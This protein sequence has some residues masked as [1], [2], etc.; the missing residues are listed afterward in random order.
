MAFLGCLVRWEKGRL[1]GELPYLHVFFDNQN[2][3]VLTNH[4]VRTCSFKKESQK[5]QRK[6]KKQSTQGSN[7]VPPNK[8]K[9]NRV[10]P[11]KKSKND[12][13][14]MS[15]MANFH[16]WLVQ[17]S[18]SQCHAAQGRFW[19]FCTKGFGVLGYFYVF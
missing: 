6:K 10:C 9:V 18:R 16:N 7:N 4:H 14:W 15:K 2:R 19:I 3:Q 17:R 11:K 8:T 1:S 5:K 12:R 13:F